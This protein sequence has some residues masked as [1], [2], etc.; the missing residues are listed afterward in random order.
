MGIYYPDRKGTYYK[1]V[2]NLL[3][4]VKIEEVKALEVNSSHFPQELLQFHQ[5]RTLRLQNLHEFPTEIAAFEHLEELY[6]LGGYYF[7]S[8]T[9]PF[10]IKLP[11]L[12][13]LW[14]SREY[15]QS[16][17]PQG[18]AGLTN[19]EYLNVDGLHVDSFPEKVLVLS[20]LKYL[21]LNACKFDKMPNEIAQMPELEVLT[22]NHN[23]L[24]KLPETLGKLSQLKKLEIKGNKLKGLPASISQLTQLQSIEAGDNALNKLPEDFGE[25]KNLEHL[26][27][28]KNKLTHLPDSLVNCKKL[29]LLNVENNKLTYLPQMLGNLPHLQVLQLRKNQLQNLPTSL[30]KL[31]ALTV[32]DIGDNPIQWQKADYETDNFRELMLRFIYERISLKAMADLSDQ[33]Q[34]FTPALATHPLGAGVV[35]C[36][37]GRTNFKI[38]ELKPALEKQGMRYQKKL[39]DQVTHLV[40]GRLPKLP[41]DEVL[42]HKITFISEAQLNQYLQAQTPPDPSKYLLQQDE[43]TPEVVN[44]I[45]GLLLSE[46]SNNVALAIELIKSGGFPPELHT[47]LFMAYKMVSDVEVRKQIKPLLEQHSSEKAKEA[48][49]QRMS[50]YSEYIDEMRLRRNINKYTKNNELDG[51]KIARHFW[52]RYRK[53]ILYL[54]S[55]GSS[56]QIKELLPTGDTLDL[57]GLKINALPNALA[58]CTQLKHVILKDCEFVTFPKVLLQLP[59]LESL[60]L[61]KNQIW[62]VP[63]ELPQLEKLKKLDLSY[64]FFDHF[65]QVLYQLPQLEQL[66][67]KS[68]HKPI[69]TADVLQN[70]ENTLPNCQ[71][72]A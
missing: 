59:Q 51:A 40:V 70:I 50:L 53:G 30:G 67:F 41:L 16:L 62:R 66:S 21:H 10:S 44:N 13:R 33:L 54:F 3:S 60:V 63:D 15:Y 8:V 45:K 7:K 48:M 55:Y 12:K 61:R 72:E 1:D 17:E 64:N 56:E 32:F 43:H 2:K 4:Q 31:K 47:E 5:L 11:Q 71:V 39:D 57:S 29:H 37:T 6:I 23:G 27:L 26:V 35:V 9:P 58:E 25:L 65:P 24:K 68:W 18:L 19:L 34:Y 69:I 38:K 22:L 49:R 36:I 20:Q 46:D 42:K 14:M 52:Q 28:T